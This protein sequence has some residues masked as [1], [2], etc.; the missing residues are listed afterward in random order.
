MTDVTSPYI[1]PFAPFRH[2]DK[3]TADAVFLPPRTVSVPEVLRW[4]APFAPR[5][6]LPAGD[7]LARRVLALFLEPGVLFGR[8]EFVES[9]ADA[10]LALLDD[11]IE[12][13]RPIEFTILGFPFKM[14]VPLKTNRRD[15]DFGELVSLARLNEIARAVARV[16]APGSRFHVFAEGPFHELN[17]ISRRW[18]DDYFASLQALATRFGIDTNLVLHD[19]NVVADE[20]PGF[21]RLWQ[22]TTEDIRAR[23]DAGD[24]KVLDAVRDAL[25][26]RFHNIANPGVTDDELRRAYLDDGTADTLRASIAERAEAGVLAYRGFLEARDRAN[27]L[28]T[29]VPGGLGAT[30]SPRPGR[31][32]VRPLPAPADKLPYHGVPVLGR[33]LTHLRID[34][35]W[36]LRHGGGRYQPVH[37]AGEADTAPFVYVEV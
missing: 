13:G 8:R 37:V 3:T 16:H 4:A 32:G 12:A 33:D 6:E 15:A 29:L 27:L 17:G 31:L 2:L 36:D 28:D 20:L 22:E 5:L 1:F 14:P 25:P 7:T 10:W 19:L 26:V 24:P 34:Y 21:R 35:L 30:V 18:A 9:R 11:A 23:R